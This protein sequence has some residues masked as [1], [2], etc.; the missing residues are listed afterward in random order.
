[1]FPQVLT[2]L[3][4]TRNCEIMLTRFGKKELGPLL[5]QALT[6]DPEVRL[7]KFPPDMEP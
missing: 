5:H 6:L 7:L 1:M 3:N 2:D 4:R